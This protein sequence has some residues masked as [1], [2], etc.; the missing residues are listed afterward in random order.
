MTTLAIGALT[1]TV[2]EPDGEMTHVR[3]VDRL[4][5]RVAD[6]GLP[7]RLDELGFSEGEWCLRRVDSSFVYDPDRHQAAAEE[8]WADSLTAALVEA[9]RSTSPVRP[10]AAAAATT[11]TGQAS[12]VHYRH[13]DDAVV[14]LFTSVTGGSLE[15]AWAWCQL[16]LVPDAGPWA[17]P[18]T[19]ALDVLARHPHT[20]LRALRAA[21]AYPGP[22]ALHRLLGLSGWCA[23][24]RIIAVAVGATGHAVDTLL[25][26]Q[27]ALRSGRL[28]AYD[29]GLPGQTVGQRPVQ[30][31]VPSGTGPARIPLGIAQALVAAGLRTDPVTVRAWAIVALVDADPTALRRRDAVERVESLADTMVDLL[32]GQPAGLQVA[33]PTETGARPTVPAAGD[34][35]VN[36][37]A[38][39]P[40]VPAAGDG[41]VAKMA[42]PARDGTEQGATTAWA[43]LVFLHNTAQA[44]NVPAL[45]ECDARLARRTL[46][47]VLHQLAGRLAPVMADDPAAL[48][49]TGLSPGDPVPA[50]EPVTADEEAALDETAA[51]WRECTWAAVAGAR[52]PSW[53]RSVEDTVAAVVRRRGRIVAEPGW[54]DVVLDLNEV[55]VEVR[56]AGLDLDPGWVP[57]LGTVVRFRYE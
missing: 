43:G 18:R 23:L 20:A 49:F 41:A 56:A 1:A 14:D 10:A 26:A 9:L 27:A 55:D 13:R 2:L 37:T 28:G 32:T 54:V 38:A 22:A 6:H 36:E 39:R 8:D 11:V 12:G 45:P 15:R 47:W 52:E 44:A 42:D 29:H 35:A 40:A 21:I 31:S 5:H 24:A 17:D 7:R 3:D 33:R 50:G 4:L 30:P 16:G 48:A 34:G 57:W 25:Q 46:C 51:V 19:A 53:R